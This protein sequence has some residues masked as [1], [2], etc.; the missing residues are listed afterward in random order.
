MRSRDVVALVFGLLFTA[1]AAAALWQSVIGTL[2]WS[3]L[4]TVTPLALVTVGVLGL[5]LSRRP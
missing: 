3:L 5:A 2:H 1:V 4:K